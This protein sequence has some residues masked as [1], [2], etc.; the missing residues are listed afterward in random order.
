[1][2]DNED[3]QDDVPIHSRRQSRLDFASPA[4][5]ARYSSYNDGGYGEAELQGYSMNYTAPPAQP[6]RDSP[7]AGYTDSPHIQERYNNPFEQPAPQQDFDVMADFNNAG[8]RY[9]HLYG[10]AK[11]E[12]MRELVKSGGRPITCVALC[13]K[14]D[15]LPHLLLP[16]DPIAHKKHTRNSQNPTVPP[17]PRT[18]PKS[19]ANPPS[20]GP[21]RRV[22]PPGTRSANHGTSSPFWQGRIGRTGGTI[23]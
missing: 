9:S 8:P 4:G 11:D 6:T 18:T 20:N 17:R 1:M 12:S 5:N 2:A 7:Y 10:T 15:A 19:K 16:S 13:P 14:G 3:D 22:T 23:V 21:T